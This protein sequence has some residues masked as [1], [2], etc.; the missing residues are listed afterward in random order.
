MERIWRTLIAVI[1]SKYQWIQ[2]CW[3]HFH[4][5]NLK[6]AQN[7]VLTMSRYTKIIYPRFEALYSSGKSIKTHSLNFTTS[8]CTR[9]EMKILQRLVDG[10][11]TVHLYHTLH[12]EMRF[13]LFSTQIGHLNQT[14]LDWNTI[15]VIIE[16]VETVAE[17]QLN[18]AFSIILVC[19]GDYDEEEGGAIQSPWYPRPYEDGKSCAY[20]IIAPLGKSI[21]L[22]FTDFDI[23]DECD[24]DSL[25]LYDGVDSNATKIGQYCGTAIPPPALSTQNHMHLLFNT[26]MSISGRGFKANYSFIDSGEL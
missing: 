24:F 2:R 18:D 8:R 11:A 25:S 13:W 22:N 7:A 19:G 12:W 10:V 6:E 23:E 3:S 14:A 1:L 15:Q 16:F 4:Y 5:L 20:N 26:D 21:V 17:I 9:E